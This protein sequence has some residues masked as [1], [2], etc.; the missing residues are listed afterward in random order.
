MSVLPDY[1]GPGLRVVFCGTAA[2]NRSAALGHYY[3]GPGNEFWP[4]L[5]K[6]GIIPL[7][8]TPDR[9]DEALHFGVGLTDLAKKRSASR[10]DDLSVEDFDVA[11]LIRKMQLY[12]PS[13]LVFHGKTSAKIAARYFG[14]GSDVALGLQEWTVGGVRTFV[15]P[16]ASAANRSTAHL[17]GKASRLAWFETL[18][19]ELSSDIGQPSV[20]V[21]KPRATGQRLRTNTQAPEGCTR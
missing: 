9:D 15:V 4:L 11:V 12:R 19:H 16:S 6:S 21:R 1:L 7:A 2:G 14:L 18:A 8:L 10:D 17:E 20:G 13:W 5:Y 3:A